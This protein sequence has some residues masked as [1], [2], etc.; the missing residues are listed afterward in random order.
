MRKGD[1]TN[2]GIVCL[3]DSLEVECESIPK[4][5]LARS[6]S[7]KNTSAF[8]CPGDGI[9]GTADFVGGGMD[10]LCGQRRRDVV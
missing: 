3:E 5:E 1:R 2:G 4:R 6:R 9:D 10:E 7:S 8:W